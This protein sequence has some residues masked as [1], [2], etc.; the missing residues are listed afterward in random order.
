MFERRT[1]KGV[2]LDVIVKEDLGRRVRGALAGYRRIL[3]RLGVDGIAEDLS[4][5]R[6][7]EILRSIS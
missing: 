1:F 3:S 5:S 7:D 4:Q 6:E 2:M